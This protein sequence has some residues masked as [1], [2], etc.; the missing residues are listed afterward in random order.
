ME[1]KSLC[2]KSEQDG[3]AILSISFEMLSK[4]VA[5]PM[6]RDFRP[7]FISVVVMGVSLSREVCA[8]VAQTSLEVF[9]EVLGA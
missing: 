6:D 2:K 3:P 5:L 8:S 4:P 9:L 1:L 7:S